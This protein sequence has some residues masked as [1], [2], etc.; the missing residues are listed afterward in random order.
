MP[1]TGFETKTKRAIIE[2]QRS[3]R[4]PD[5]ATTENALRI[6][7]SKR[8]RGAARVRKGEQ[9]KPREESKPRPCCL[10][11]YPTSFGDYRR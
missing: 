5:G 2:C 4:T 3:A 1:A 10:L 9:I 6:V 11:R 8:S 7:T